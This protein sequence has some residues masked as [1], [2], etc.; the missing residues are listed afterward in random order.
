[1]RLSCD[2]SAALLYFTQGNIGDH[3]KEEGSRFAVGVGFLGNFKEKSR[4]GEG[5][6]GH[7]V[8]V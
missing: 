6:C 4:F 2:E 7:D 3:L 1:L 8:E 5:F